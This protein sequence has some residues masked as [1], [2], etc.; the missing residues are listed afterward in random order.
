MIGI[1][2][3]VGGAT[4]M[5]A[6]CFGSEVADFF[7]KGKAV[8]FTGNL[9]EFTKDQ[10]QFQYRKNNFAKDIIV[11]EATFGT[12]RSSAEKISD[13]IKK[14]QD[15]RNNTQPIRKKTGGSTFKNP[16]GHKSWELIDKSGCRGLEFG[17][18]QISEKHCNFII[19]NGK[20]RASDLISLVQEVRS[21]VKEKFDIYLEWEIKRFG[22]F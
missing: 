11:V 17:G 4:V 9:I 8:D 1:P 5:N 15:Y 14:Y 2:G 6:G 22:E 19:N 21:R 10:C 12:Q 13:L 16:I 20:A 7:I 3:M 18:A